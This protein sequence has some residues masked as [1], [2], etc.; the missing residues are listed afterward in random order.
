M[1]WNYL[2]NTRKS[3][4]VAFPVVRQVV[5]PARCI[6]RGNLASVQSRWRKGLLAGSCAQRPQCR[7]G[8]LVCREKTLDAEFVE[9]NIIRCA[10]SCQGSK[11]LEASLPLLHFNRRVRQQ[12][13]QEKLPASIGAPQ[14]I[15]MI[16]PSRH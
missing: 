9:R 8:G 16:L 15:T 1:V 4:E 11:E 7:V 14:E 3:P 12:L 10:E 6:G 13:V 5:A 2:Y